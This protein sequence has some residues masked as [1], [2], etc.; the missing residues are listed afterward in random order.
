MS[1]T[2][3]CMGMKGDGKVEED[4]GE[5]IVSHNAANMVVELVRSSDCIGDD[6]TA[7]PEAGRDNS[8]LCDTVT[9]MFEII[10][11]KL[12]EIDAKIVEKGEYH[13]KN[14][15]QDVKAEVATR[16]L[17][18][19]EKEQEQEDDDND[20]LE[21]GTIKKRMIEKGFGFIQ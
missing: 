17:A 6:A 10:M 3:A 7:S 9:S 1:I 8:I 13:K 2:M 4:A 21:K 11:H 18:R 20:G 5:L 19:L 15:I 12:M 14:L 16:R